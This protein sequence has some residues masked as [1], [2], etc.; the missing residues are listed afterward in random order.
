MVLDSFGVGEAPD[1]KDFGDAGSNTLKSVSESKEYK[2][3]NLK[4][5]GLHNIDSVNVLDECDTIIGTYGKM[6]ELSKGKDTTTGHWEMMGI[7][8]ETPMPTFPNGFPDD[9]MK[10]FEE[11]IGTK[12]L[13]NKPYSGTEVIKDYGEEHLKTGYPIIYTSTDSVFQIAAHD[14]VIPL[15]KLYEICKIARNMLTGDIAVSRVIARPFIGEAGNFTRTSNRH[16]YSLVPRYNVL[17][18]LK[19]SGKDVIS[20]GKISDIFAGSGITEAVRTTGN[21][22]GL[23]KT[24]EYLNKDFEGLC[25]V[26]LVD[27]DMLYGHRNDIDGYAKALTEVDIWLDKFIPNMKEDDLLI[28]TA[29][30]GCDPKTVSTD[31]SREYVPVLIYHKNI[32]PKNLGTR[33]GF[34]DLGKTILDIFEIENK[35]SGTSFKNEVM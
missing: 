24:L 1:A 23:N 31:H 18:Y 3:N 9:F 11:A 15:E 30:H 7:I 21:T 4:K 16:D 29:D 12:T 8:S 5:L 14:D 19:D 28:I 2:I 17:N 26:N 10:K 25:F 33:I 35:I 22:D 6:Q 32:K 13:C 20:I 34:T 27:F